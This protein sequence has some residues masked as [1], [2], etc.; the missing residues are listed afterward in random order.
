[1][2]DNKYTAEVAIDIGGKPHVMEFD[3]RAVAQVHSECGA[4]VLRNIFSVSPETIAKI[5]LA[6]L[7][8]HHPEV[9]LDMVMSASL[10]Y[11]PTLTLLDRA[12]TFF[13]FGADGVSAAKD[14]EPAPDSKKN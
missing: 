6:G 5:I 1:M 8:K 7:K 3:W 14:D 10:P 4:D 13:Y 12:I 9:T 11:I 2:A